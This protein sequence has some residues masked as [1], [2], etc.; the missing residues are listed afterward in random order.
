MY[1]YIILVWPT[2]WTTPA[3]GSLFVCECVYVWVSESVCPRTCRHIARRM[4]NGWLWNAVRFNLPKRDGAIHYKLYLL[5]LTMAVDNFVFK[6]INGA[7]E[8]SYESIMY[9]FLYNTIK[10]PYQPKHSPSLSTIFQGLSLEHRKH[11]PDLVIERS[12]PGT[13]TSSTNRVWIFT[14]ETLHVVFPHAYKFAD[15][16]EEVCVIMV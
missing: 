12:A 2:S 14:S 1:F 3:V 8:C 11:C 4:M 9:V 5:K 13:L 10:W 7:F 16:L 6:I 15:C